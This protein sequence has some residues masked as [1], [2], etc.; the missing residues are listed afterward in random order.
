MKFAKEAGLAV[1]EII[2][3]LEPLGKLLGKSATALWTMAMKEV[4]VDKVMSKIWMWIFGILI[5]I[6]ITLSP[7][8]MNR[9]WWGLSFLCIISVIIF[10]LLLFAKVNDYIGQKINPEFRALQYILDMAKKDEDE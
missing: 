4:E 5:A 1:K 2:K 9:D 10:V 8:F 3:S 7:F 6:S